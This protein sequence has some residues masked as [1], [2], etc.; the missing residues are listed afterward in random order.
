MWKMPNGY[1]WFLQ[2]L[3][4]AHLEQKHQWGEGIGL[5]D[6]MFI[7]NEEWAN[8]QLDQEFVGQ[9]A[10]ALDLDTKTLYAVGGFT[11]KKLPISSLM[12]MDL[13]CP[14]PF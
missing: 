1:D 12:N 10:H 14:M 8:F 9:S 6:N 4:S 3:C 11:S 5:E 13:C 7:T 2:S